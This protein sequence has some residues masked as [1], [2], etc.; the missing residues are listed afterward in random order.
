MN[1]LINNSSTKFVMNSKELAELMGKRHDNVSRDIKDEIEKL[2]QQGISA[3]L[4]FEVSE[5]KDSTGRTLPMYLLTK[6]GAMQ[7][8]TRYDAKVRHDV[9]TYL[10]NL[11]KKMSLPQTF[12]E[13]LRM[14]A[15]EVEERERLQI[16]NMMMK[17][18]AD[19][20]DE[21]VDRNLLT[22]FRDTAKE[23]GLTQTVFIS[24]LLSLG[25]VYYSKSKNLKPIACYAEKGLFEIKEVATPNYTTTQ[26]MLTP[27]G[28]ETFRLIKDKISSAGKKHIADQKK[29][30]EG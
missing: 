15:N 6:E 16:E 14:L 4:K 22:N 20:F 17:P 21:L 8:A 30:Q 27:K 5:Y 28:R 24:G 18:K 1:E 29:K 3:Q 26:T 7:M 25:Y 13:A 12:S 10:N 2:G 9:I 11:E 23:L 19:Y